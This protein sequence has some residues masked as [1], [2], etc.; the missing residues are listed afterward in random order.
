MPPSW[1]LDFALPLTFIALL[2]PTL[3][4]RPAVA[5]A[6]AAG[7]VG[8]IC[9]GWPYKLGLVAAALAGI[10]VG[11]WA[12][13]TQG[14]RAPTGAAEM[15]G[16]ALWLTLLGMGLITYGIRLSMILLL[17]RFKLRWAAPGTAPGAAGCALRHHLPGAAASE[18]RAGYLIWQP[19]AAGGDHRSAGGVAHQERAADDWR[20]DGGAVGVASVDG[21]MKTRNV[22]DQWTRGWSLNADCPR[23]AEGYNEGLDQ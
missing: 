5:A 21:Q 13:R 14:D 3:K 4:D 16:T 2:A 11:V 23:N 9:A 6:L 8:V 22:Q 7:A 19:T 15:T 1:S 10:A 12:D 20:R 18:R 17:G